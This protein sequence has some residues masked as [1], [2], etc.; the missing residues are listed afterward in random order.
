[1]LASRLVG[2][3]AAVPII[4][5]TFFSA[6]RADDQLAAMA[7]AADQARKTVTAWHGP[8]SSPPLQ[9]NKNIY[10]I[11]CSSQGV[12]CTRAAAGAK[13]AG[14]AAGWTVRVID[15]KGDPGTWNGAIQSAI[16]A[17][18]DGIILAA[19]PPA[20]V[21]DALERAKKSSV[22]IVSIF[23]PIPAADSPVFAWVRP[24]HPA[25]GALMAD[26]IAEDSHGKARVLIIEDR[27][28]GELRQRVEAFKK[29]I[30]KCAGCAVVASEDTTLG[31][32]V[33]RLPGLISSQLGAHPDAN[34]IVV[35]Y[36]AAAFFVGEGVRQ[37]GRTGK[38]KVVGYEGDPQ[39]ID[40]I[41][42]GT[43]AATIADPA[44]WMG[45][46]AVDELNRSFAGAPAQNTPV[47]FKLIDKSN[48]PN[49]KGWLGDYDFKARYRKLWGLK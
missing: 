28:F 22:T 25:Q 15:G 21:G 11:T 9:K 44:E 16:A 2:L 45:W 14:E 42:T 12:G 38:V 34:Y 43:Q 31:T 40:A 47:V 36:D 33:Q 29:E 19:V 13:E 41:R 3:C 23:N 5:G 49:T 48:V 24:D 37:A 8:T 32:M 7:A 18:A 39:T 4:A 20:L 10:V 30:A 17:K 46:Q 35:Q 26:W 27:E 1:M 6:A